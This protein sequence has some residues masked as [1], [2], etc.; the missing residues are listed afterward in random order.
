MS[1]FGLFDTKDEIWLGN[2]KGPLCIEDEP[3]AHKAA[4]LIGA[5]MDWSSG[6][7]AVRPSENP[8]VK[9]DEIPYA[10]SVEEAADHLWFTEMEKRTG[11]RRQRMEMIMRGGVI[12]SREEDNLMRKAFEEMG[13]S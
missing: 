1:S 13:L 12:Q 3:L 6:R 9:R 5:R 10:R 11:I 7:I 4:E 2:S 8:T